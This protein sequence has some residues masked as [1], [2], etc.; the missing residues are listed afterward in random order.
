MALDFDVG[1]LSR[2]CAA[3]D[4]E[5]APGEVVY[6]VLVAEGADVV[7]RDYAAETWTEPPGDAI[8]W[9]RS[10]VP[11]PK[12]KAPAWAPNAILLNYFESLDETSQADVRYVAA[13]L[14][15][16]R[17]ILAE[18]DPEMEAED[19][20]SVDTETGQRRHAAAST[21]MPES[22]R[23][24]CPKT[25]KTFLVAK[26]EPTAERIAEISEELTRLLQ[27]DGGEER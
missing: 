17:R 19:A 24:Q 14:L 7:R 15:I 6:S 2:R 12:A 26:V 5:L 1:R 3:T 10:R 8:G 4:R 23:L 21:G 9:W 16:R 22:M 25:E 20:Q 13:L 27:R 11:D 18:C